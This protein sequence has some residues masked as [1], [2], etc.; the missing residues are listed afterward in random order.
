MDPFSPDDE[1]LLD[2]SVINFYFSEFLKLRF[3]R[4]IIFSSK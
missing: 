2:P 3:F 4:T 1:D